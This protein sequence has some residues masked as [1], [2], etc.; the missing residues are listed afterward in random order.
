M[1]LAYVRKARLMLCENSDSIRCNALKGL[2]VLCDDR[3]VIAYMFKH[4]YDIFIIRSFE[5]TASSSEEKTLALKLILKII[6]VSPDLVSRDIANSLSAVA[7]YRKDECRLQAL[8]VL[9]LLA[10]RNPLVASQ[11]FGLITLSDAVLDQEC[12]A[13]KASIILT[14]LQL[15]DSPDTRRLFSYQSIIMHMYAP[16]LEIDVQKGKETLNRWEAAAEVVEIML[17]TYSGVFLLASSITGGLKAI[18][19]LLRQPVDLDL[20]YI[21]LKMLSRVISFHTI[22]IKASYRNTSSGSTGIDKRNRKNSSFFNDTDD[23]DFDNS[24]IPLNLDSFDSD[25]S[26]K[27][28]VKNSAGEDEM[29]EVLQQYWTRD[30]DDLRGQNMLDTYH[31]VLL[32]AFYHVGLVPTLMHLASSFED[33]DVSILAN[34]VLSTY[35]NCSENLLPRNLHRNILKITTTFK[36]THSFSK[37]EE[38]SRDT[39]QIQEMQSMSLLKSLSYRTGL[40]IYRSQI[41]NA[42]HMMKN[43]FYMLAHFIRLSNRSMDPVFK[44]IGESQREQNRCFQ[45]AGGVLTPGDHKKIAYFIKQKKSMASTYSSVESQVKKSRVIQTK[46]VFD[47]DWIEISNLFDGALQNQNHLKAVM[48]SY[49]KFFKRIAGFYRVTGED[50]AYFAHLTWVQ[51]HMPYVTVLTKMMGLLMESDSGIDFIAEDRRGKILVQIVEELN[52]LVS[53]EPANGDVNTGKPNR[54]SRR[55]STNSMEFLFCR[56]NVNKTMVREYFTLIGYLSS[57]MKGEQKLNDAGLFQIATKLAFNSDFDYISRLLI[58]NV[59]ISRRGTP[60]QNAYFDNILAETLNKGTT[61]SMSLLVHTLN[62]SRLV[63]V[64]RYS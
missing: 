31:G 45:T 54:L 41:I 2:H 36:H 3:A 4:K 27:H 43:A 39:S 24:S 1:E 32:L 58:S 26:K 12:K 49:D 16:L 30:I 38:N 62:A 5:G 29:N 42:H 20:L 64:V 40:G 48:K 14:L 61:V 53:L 17:R 52:A 23:D 35:I 15:L 57:T 44:L 56:S 59:D 46:D 37:P 8:S 22:K 60:A 10:S 51:D 11:T 33:D 28:N 63:L 6:E 21:I 47:W 13:F 9:R 25:I 50:K 18:V 55:F 34:S 7:S 19:D